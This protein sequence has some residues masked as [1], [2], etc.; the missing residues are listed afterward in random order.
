MFFQEDKL[1]V[2]GES[3]VWQRIHTKFQVLFS[4]TNN[5]KVFMNAIYCIRDW[6]FMILETGG[7]VCGLHTRVSYM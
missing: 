7:V 5:E 1:D 6:H 2:S 4:L 3:S